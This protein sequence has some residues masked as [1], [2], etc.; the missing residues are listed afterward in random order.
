MAQIDKL[1]EHLIGNDGSDLHLLAGDPPRMRQF[2][3]LTNISDERMNPA[4]AEA[5]ITEIM[6]YEARQ[7]LDERDGGAVG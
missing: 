2:G 3:D 4:D 1:L 6:T 5:L 7:Q